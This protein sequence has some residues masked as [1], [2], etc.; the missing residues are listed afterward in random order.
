MLARVAQT[1][2]WIARD[3]ERAESFARLLELF[4]DE[5]LV[6]RSAER[7]LAA[8]ARPH[9]E[10]ESIWRYTTETRYADFEAFVRD[11]MTPAYVTYT[12][13]EIDANEVRRRF[14]ACR[15]GAGFALLQPMRVNLY[16]QPRR[17]G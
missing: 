13:D 15:E 1:L 7:A 6:Q 9:F 14:E 8:H 16:R 10:S 17:G 12:R 3:L 2:Y 5:T 11:M 4:H